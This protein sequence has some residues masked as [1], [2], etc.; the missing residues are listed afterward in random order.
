MTYILQV[1]QKKL[2]ELQQNE[3]KNFPGFYEIITLIF[4]CGFKKNYFKS[5]TIG[6]AKEFVTRPQKT[7]SGQDL[8]IKYPFCKKAIQDYLGKLENKNNDD[9]LFSRYANDSGQRLLTRH[10]DKI[11][12][13]FSYD[14]IR[15]E[16]IQYI[17]NQWLK[18]RDINVGFTNEEIIDLL[19]EEYGVDTQ[20][21]IDS[22]RPPQD[23]SYDLRSSIV[24]MLQTLD[25]LE[26]GELCLKE[27]EKQKKMDL[28]RYCSAY[29]KKMK[30]GPKE[31][32][33]LEI[34]LSK[35]LEN[36]Y[37]GINLQKDVPIVD[38]FDSIRNAQE[39]QMNE[40]MQKINDDYKTSDEEVPLR[41]SSRF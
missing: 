9:L 19:S 5:I 3:G 37:K 23:G 40:D 24:K 28:I 22:I 8:I 12:P 38:P 14:D 7:S 35:E 2:N 21:I 15:N 18:N 27:L 30:Y 10:M 33:L 1:A 11:L 4:Y 31:K 6:Q 25:E 39:K 41:H 13:L 26:K 36:I 29:I 16:G 34:Q 20:T 17:Y 32:G